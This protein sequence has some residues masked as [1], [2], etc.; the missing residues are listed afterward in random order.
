[1]PPIAFARRFAAI[2]LDWSLHDPK[3]GVR[4]NTKRPSG[5]KNGLVCTVAPQKWLVLVRIPVEWNRYCS[6][7]LYGVIPAKAGIRYSAAPPALLDRPPSQAMT[8]SVIP[9][10]RNLL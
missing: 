3:S 7:H 10:E 8:G 2:A 1:M 9:L 6:H 5:G 4:G